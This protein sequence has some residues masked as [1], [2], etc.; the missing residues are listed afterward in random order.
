[1]HELQNM[2]VSK[3]AH[4]INRSPEIELNCTYNLENMHVKK[5]I[6]SMSPSG[7]QNV[8]FTKLFFDL[9][10]KKYQIVF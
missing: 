5:I 2:C 8:R 9:I 6:T 1:M 3:I 4:L 7:L 10:N